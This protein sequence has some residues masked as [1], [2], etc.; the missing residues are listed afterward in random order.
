MKRLSIYAAI[1]LALIGSAMAAKETLM[2]PTGKLR[3]VVLFKFKP[4][5]TAQQI[6]AVEVAFGQLPKKIPTIVGF[7][8]GVNVS[9]EG[10]D[11]GYTH[12]FLVTFDDD[13]GRDAYLPHP[14]HQ[15]FVKLVRPLLA[16]VHVIDY[17][18]KE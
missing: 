10:K 9:P 8:W 1:V 3:H 7:E 11:L 14:A 6:K 2:T 4:E 17:V 13:A 15:E 18:V 16:E 5:A 12:C